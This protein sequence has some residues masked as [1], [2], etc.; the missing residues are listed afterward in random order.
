MEAF[1]N[2]GS[3]MIVLFV[4]V[5]LG[6]LARKMH[7]I[8]QDFNDSLSKVVMNITCPAVV[9]DSVLSNENLPSN[10][11]VWQILGVSFIVFIPV[12][13]VS[14]LI[15][16]LYRIPRNQRG[17][18]SFSICFSNVGFIGFAV[19]DSILGSES[20]LYI[21][22][23]NI[24][25]NLVLYSVGAWMISRTGSV[26]LSFKE[27]LSYIRKNLISPVMACCVI[28]LFLALFHVTDSGVIGH[29]CELV[30]AMTA[31]AAMLVVGSTLA[32]Y[33]IKSMVTNG[34]AYVSTF[35]RLIIVPAV[36]FFVGGL[37][38][39]DPY[40]LA[41]L[42]L[43]CATPAAMMGI[44]MGILYGGDLDSLSQCMFLT[45]I[46]SIVTIPLVTMFIA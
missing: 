25:C 30:G 12:I 23:Y 17:G 37:F 33:K 46:F 8:D 1:L 24:A 15:P 35:S 21:A 40:Q 22:I 36:V 9:L 10:E 11:V 20:V 4:T 42:T 5:S 27:Q 18:H 14:L 6:Y 32:T 43:V 41:S 29:T 7:M 28:A 16:Q 31:P 39:S 44:T 38:I 13:L 26:K 19:C 2:A 34:W 45:T 3:M